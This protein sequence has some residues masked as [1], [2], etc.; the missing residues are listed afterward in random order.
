MW[1]L[2]CLSG[3]ALKSR[4]LVL[5]WLQWPIHFSRR[6]KK[7]FLIWD[8]NERNLE[9]TIPWLFLPSSISVRSSHKKFLTSVLPFGIVHFPKSVSSY[10][11]ENSKKM[12]TGWNNFIVKYISP[13]SFQFFFPGLHF[14]STNTKDD[15][16]FPGKLSV[17]S[18]PP[19]CIHHLAPQRGP[20]CGPVSRGNWPGRSVYAGGVMFQ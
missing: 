17:L 14:P 7:F 3:F 8:L 9:R 2:K 16:H 6:Q 10:D 18:D 4:P 12:W 11:H 1:S 15:H 13:D 19:A 20:M 5:F